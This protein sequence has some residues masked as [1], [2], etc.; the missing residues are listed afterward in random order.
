MVSNQVGRQVGEMLRYWRKLRRF[1]Q[2]DLALTANIS[3][4]HLSFVETGRSKPSYDLLLH[5]A[6]VLQ[7]PLN[8]TNSLLVA[9]GYAPRYSDWQLEDDRM[10]PVRMVLEQFLEQHHP[11][12]AMVINR[13]YD[14]LKVNRGFRHLMD[15]LAQ[16]YA[17]VYQYTNVY[18]LLFA[19]QGIHPY[20]ANWEAIYPVLLGR[21]REESIAYQSEALSQ[22][23]QECVHH[24]AAE[25][26]RIEPNYQFP[27]MMLSLQKNGQKLDL[28]STMTTFG[29][30][31]DIT[32]KEL[33]IEN[34]FPANEETRQF[35]KQA[36]LR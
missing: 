16:D 13:T 14:V 25:T 12:P 20:I 5:L 9:A 4:R 22:L 3:A 28:F 2:L 1:S 34:M 35:F 7:L 17:G 26:M 31:I 32:T 24:S 21:L 18:R 11:Y 8:H 19:K 29:T 10:T 36:A 33:R 6:E 27:V 23:Y 30:A 15:W